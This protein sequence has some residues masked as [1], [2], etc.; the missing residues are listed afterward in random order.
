[1]SDIATNADAVSAELTDDE[2]LAEVTPGMREVLH[3]RA[4]DYYFFRL[5]RTFYF[6]AIF[7]F[8]ASLQSLPSLP[9]MVWNVASVV[10]LA[11]AAYL[12]FGFALIWPERWERKLLAKEI[13]HRR[14]QGKWRWDR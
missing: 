11:G 1:M 6:I 4:R 13:E 12:A 14:R 9:A 2:L 3:E 7:A 10:G 5:S 8:L